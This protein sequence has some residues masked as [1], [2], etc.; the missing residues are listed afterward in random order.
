[1]LD[2]QQMCKL[3]KWRF[4][5]SAFDSK[6]IDDKPLSENTLYDALFYLKIKMDLPS[7]F[8][9]TGSHSFNVL[10]SIRGRGYMPLI[11]LKVGS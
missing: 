10:D 7:I 11:G 2:M 1:M 3:V 6:L 5:I 9:S 8:R 4:S